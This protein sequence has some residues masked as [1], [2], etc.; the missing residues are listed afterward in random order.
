MRLILKWL[1][2]AAALYVAAAL[3]SGIQVADQKALL[4]A[5]LVIGLVN[6]LVKPLVVVLTLPI[7]LV[8]LGLFYLVVN[9]GML[10]LAARIT[11]GFELSGFWTAFFGAI[12]ISLVSMALGSILPDKNGPDAHRSH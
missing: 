7:T 4:I 1:I 12:V 10:L 6:A 9:A 8:T 2:T 5:A 3:F 11:P